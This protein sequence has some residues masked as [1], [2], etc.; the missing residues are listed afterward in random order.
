MLSRTGRIATRLS[1]ATRVA[2]FN[3]NRST[4]PRAA[5]QQRRQFHGH[6]QGSGH[7][8][9]DKSL[10]TRL[11]DAYQ[12]K[13]KKMVSGPGKGNEDWRE[14][15]AMGVVQTERGQQE[16]MR[17]MARA[18]AE[19]WKRGDREVHVSG[20]SR[21]AGNALLYAQ[22][23]HQKGLVHP[24]TGEVLAKPGV[25]VDSLTLAD[26]VPHMGRG[27]GTAMV[28]GEMQK[29]PYDSLKVPPNVKSYQ[30]FYANGEQ[31]HEFT[32]ANI[33]VE[34]P[35]THSTHTIVPHALHKDVVG[36]KEGD[37]NVTKLVASEALRALA[38]KGYKFSTD[39]VLT[40]EAHN[41]ALVEL[42]QN[43]PEPGIVE[44]LIKHAFGGGPRYFPKNDKN[45]D[46]Q[47]MKLRPDAKL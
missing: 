43:P 32:Q 39:K 8:V 40:P 7:A 12:G 18:H 2:P 42:E 47:T 22:I 31:R 34:S 26:A 37:P 41:K 44:K 13:F 5:Y 36:G 9:K 35:E 38:A 1:T 10:G 29:V 21:G 25:I 27:F 16:R 6:F 17:E 3:F 14:W 19:A 46:M 11:M 20:G 4:R 45:M 30:H 33:P 23:L 15:P 24:D 28:D